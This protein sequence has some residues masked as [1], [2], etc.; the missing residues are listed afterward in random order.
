MK[1]VLKD[2]DGNVAQR[3]IKDLCC[4]GDIGDEDP[5]AALVIVELDDT[6][7]Y[8]PI[9]QFICEEWTDD[10]VVVKEDWA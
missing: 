4:D 7:T 8:L 9:D 3:R 1:L 2:L 6:L 5:Q 10:T